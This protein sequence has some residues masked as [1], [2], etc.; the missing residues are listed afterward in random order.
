MLEEVKRQPSLNKKEESPCEEK[1]RP[2]NNNIQVQ[3]YAPL[4]SPPMG[5]MWTN[6][7]PFLCPFTWMPYTGGVQ[8]SYAM[9]S[10]PPFESQWFYGKDGLPCFV[11]Y[12]PPISNST[13]YAY[14][15]VYV[16]GKRNDLNANGKF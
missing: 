12:G 3:Q 16:N 6:W 14:D 2:T 13:P 5:G 8:G 15:E 10:P 11:P 1:P 4:S 7:D 9:P